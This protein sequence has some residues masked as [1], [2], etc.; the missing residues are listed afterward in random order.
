MCGVLLRLPGVV[1][2]Q[3]LLG[4]WF[5]LSMGYLLSVRTIDSLVLQVFLHTRFL[6]FCYSKQQAASL[7]ALGLRGKEMAVGNDLGGR[8]LMEMATVRM[9]SQ[10]L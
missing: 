6:C 3:K 1:W 8:G 2:K 9:Q 5:L 10:D 7:I 4:G